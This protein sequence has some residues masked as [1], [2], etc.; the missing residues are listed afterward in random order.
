MRNWEQALGLSAALALLLGCGTSDTSGAD[1]PRGNNAVGGNTA[2][3][4]RDGSG[5]GAGGSNGDF[6]NTDGTLPPPPTGP[7][8]DA[9]DGVNESDDPDDQKCGGLKIKPEIEMEIIP[10]NILLV[11]DKSGSMMD[12]WGTAMPPHSKWQDAIEAIPAALEPLQDQVSVGAIIFPGNG[13]CGVAA[14]G[15]APNIELQEGPDFLAAWDAFV[16]ANGPDGRTP[17]L[18]GLQAADAALTAALPD[19]VGITSVV[20]V[21]DGAPN[22]SGGDSNQSEPAANM[23]PVIANWL[24]QDVKTYVVGLPAGDEPTDT[25]AF[26]A[27]LNELAVAGGTTQYIP[28]DDPASLQAE[29][30]KIIGENVTTNFDSCTIPLDEQPPSLDKLNLL[31]VKDGM[32]NSVDRDL[33]ASGGWTVDA[34]GEN[35][36][37]QGTF[38]E[39]AKMG[40]YDEISVVFGCTEAP[41]LEPPP[42]L[43]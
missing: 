31:V 37:L 3:A 32:E 19:L 21:T 11:F 41:P 28:A 33:G 26:I 2:T 38:C 17:L 24:A 43:I 1:G 14:A 5:S 40:E 22:C 7:L 8:Q 29:M 10:G 4:G 13:E 23:T 27:L 25:M 6:G 16:M 18:A 34:A 9:G 30:A 36:I 12:E 15:T 20:I 39:L 35:I 42:P